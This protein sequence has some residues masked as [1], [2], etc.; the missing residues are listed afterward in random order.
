MRN[1]KQHLLQ[2]NN[3]IKNA[4]VKLNVLGKDAILF[5]SI[6]GEQFSM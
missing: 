1:I 6:F 5:K 3:T 2:H 4:L